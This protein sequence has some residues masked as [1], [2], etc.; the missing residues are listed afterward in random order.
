MTNSVARPMP[1]AAQLAW[2]RERSFAL[3]CHFG[4]NTFYGREW[5]DGSLDPAGFAP[6]ALDCRQWVAVA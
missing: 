1:T 6:T 4:I 3:F 5:S 2:Q